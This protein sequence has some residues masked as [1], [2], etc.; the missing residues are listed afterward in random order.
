MGSQTKRNNQDTKKR[1]RTGELLLQAWDD[2]LGDVIAVASMRE[3][4]RLFGVDNV[5]TL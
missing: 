1:G 5:R 4:L 2:A 3:Q